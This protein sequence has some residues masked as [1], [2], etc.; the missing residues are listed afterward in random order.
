MKMQTIGSYT[1]PFKE[2]FVLYRAENGVEYIGAALGLY[3]PTPLVRPAAQVLE[4]ARALPG[5]TVSE[6]TA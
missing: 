3:S 5:Y 4:E 1:T 6:V 2:T